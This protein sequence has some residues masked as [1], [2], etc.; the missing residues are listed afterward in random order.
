MT[1]QQN[2]IVIDRYEISKDE[3]GWSNLRVN[4]EQWGNILTFSHETASLKPN[5]QTGI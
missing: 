5:S 1:I 4:D 3:S 2:W